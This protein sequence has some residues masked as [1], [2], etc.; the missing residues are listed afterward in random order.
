MEWTQHIDGVW[1]LTDANNDHRAGISVVTARRDIPEHYAW[2]AFA[3][4]YP[5]NQDLAVSGAAS[6]LDEAKRQAKE[7]LGVMTAKD[8]P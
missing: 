8:G 1:R 2:T 4:G 5:K 6:N 7:A 3:P